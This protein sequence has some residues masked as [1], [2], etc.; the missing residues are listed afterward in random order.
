MSLTSRSLADL[1]ELL[2]YILALKLSAAIEALMCICLALRA[3]VTVNL[4]G[5][6]RVWRDLGVLLRGTFT[7]WQKWAG[8]N[9][10]SAFAGLA[11]SCTWKGRVSG[12]RTVLGTA[13][14][15]NG[16]AAKKDLGSCKSWVHVTSV[17]FQGRGTAPCWALHVEGSDP[18]L[19]SA[20]ARLHLSFQLPNNKII[21]Y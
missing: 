19:W 8:R 15:E 10:S 3:V 6:S 4:Q 21:T 17:P 16:S 5:F 1:P 9:L 18:S 20:L 2:S 12:N 14:V 7:G 13:H 11:E